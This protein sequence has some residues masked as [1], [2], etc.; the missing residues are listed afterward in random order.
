MTA[1]HSRREER[2]VREGG[3]LNQ[4][5]MGAPVISPGPHQGVLSCRGAA[6]RMNGGLCSPHI[7]GSFAAVSPGSYGQEGAAAGGGMWEHGCG[8]FYSVFGRME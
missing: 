7:H 3:R 4:G 5:D 2:E 1:N 8:S 6:A